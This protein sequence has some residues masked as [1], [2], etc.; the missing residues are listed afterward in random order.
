LK[1]VVEFYLRAARAAF[2]I[3]SVWFFFWAVIWQAIWWQPPTLGSLW[4]SPSN[5][6]NLLGLAVSFCLW[7]F[8]DMI[9]AH[10]ELLTRISLPKWHRKAAAKTTEKKEDDKQPIY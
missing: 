5:F 3:L 7:I 6:T 10:P 4:S 9:F 2:Q 1:L 8:I